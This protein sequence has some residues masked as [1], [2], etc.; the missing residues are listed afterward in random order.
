MPER[1]KK[2]SAMLP[3]IIV[4]ATLFA[5]GAYQ[6]TRPKERE[7]NTG[8][9]A[10]ENPRTMQAP[11]APAVE[12]DAAQR[13]AENDPTTAETAA[14]QPPVS[15][16]SILDEAW[17]TALTID[18]AEP[19][20]PRVLSALGLQQLGKS[21]NCAPTLTGMTDAAKT[22]LEEVSCLATDGTRFE[23]RFDGD[24]DGRLEAIAPNRKQVTIRK[25]E[26]NFSVRTEA[27]EE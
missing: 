3:L 1:Q 2:S 19:F 15:A 7:V 14:P 27:S 10:P 25:D 24:N 17:F 13:A 9:V 23:V 6:S 18:Q 12:K 5:F 8:F 16:K 26:T 20:K 4:G 11:D 22:A 21:I